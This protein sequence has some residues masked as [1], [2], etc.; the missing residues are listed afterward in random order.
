M[1][2]SCIIASEDSAENSLSAKILQKFPYQ[3]NERQSDVS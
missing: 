2:A 1:K 3:E